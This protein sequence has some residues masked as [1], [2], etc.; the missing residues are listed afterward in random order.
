MEKGR[1]PYALVKELV[2]QKKPT[3]R[4]VDTVLGQYPKRDKSKLK[5][6]VYSLISRF[7]HGTHRSSKSPKRKTQ[8][9]AN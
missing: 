6:E 9:K 4:I 7:K 3:R 1:T 5:A 2:D 8:E